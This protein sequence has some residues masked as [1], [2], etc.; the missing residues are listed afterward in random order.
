MAETNIETQKHL[1]I[2][3]SVLLLIIA[4]CIGSLFI[5]T[6]ANEI[7]IERVNTHIAKTYITT[8]QAKEGFDDMSEALI[9]MDNRIQ[10]KLNKIDDKLGN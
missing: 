2:P 10:N 3:F 9:R 7:A 8:D 4:G 5:A 6:K 1:Y